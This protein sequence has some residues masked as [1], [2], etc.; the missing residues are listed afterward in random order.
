M[1]V[2][3]RD[4]VSDVHAHLPGVASVLEHAA[5]VEASPG[6]LVVG[7]EPGSFL[8]NQLSE[9][10]AAAAVRDA[11]RARLGPD[12]AVEI[13]SVARDAMSGT[14]A[15]RA[16]EVLRARI[17]E[18]EQVVRDHPIVAAAVEIL[19]AELREV[20]LAPELATA[21]SWERRGER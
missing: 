12:V 19:G 18:A 11:A 14:L 17:A 6:R 20:H 3:Y 7:F 1:L 15:K 16:S 4:I 13:V 2:A 5:L 9:G 21:A 10:R 8:A